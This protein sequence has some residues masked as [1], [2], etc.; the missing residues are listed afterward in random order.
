MLI[1]F[2]GL[3]FS[4]PIRSLLTCYASFVPYTQTHAH[5]YLYKM[6]A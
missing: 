2:G 4:S 3:T 6:N 1:L 5:I